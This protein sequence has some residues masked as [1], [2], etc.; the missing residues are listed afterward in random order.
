MSKVHPVSQETV[1]DVAQLETEDDQDPQ[2]HLDVMDPKDPQE[3]LDFQGD[4]ETTV[5]QD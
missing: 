2:G 5:L 1:D 4:Q 3:K